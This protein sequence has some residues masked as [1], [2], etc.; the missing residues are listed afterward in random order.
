[1][2][3]EKSQYVDEIYQLVTEICMKMAGDRGSGI[4]LV[5][6]ISKDDAKEIIKK[7]MIALPDR[8]FYSASPF[9]LYDMLGLIGKNFILFQV[10]ENL[11]EDDYAYHLI[12]F[13]KGLSFTIAA[14]Y[15]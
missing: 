10:Q 15:Y 11:D 12:D 3:P 8:Y 2:H 9:V 4:P 6:N 5:L 14:K 13:I 7:I 1:M